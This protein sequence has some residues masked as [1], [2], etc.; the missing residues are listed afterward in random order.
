[1]S[2]VLD[3]LSELPERLRDHRRRGALTQTEA[4]RLLSVAERTYQGWEAGTAFPQPRHRRAIAAW[5]RN[6]NAVAAPH[7]GDTATAVNQGG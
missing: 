3:I 6:D 1:M 7:P 5:L 4:A 2:S